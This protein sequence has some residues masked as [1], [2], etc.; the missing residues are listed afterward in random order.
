MALTKPSHSADLSQLDIAH[1]SFSPKGVTVYLSKQSQQ[2]KQVGSFFFLSLKTTK[3][4][5]QH[6]KTELLPFIWRQGKPCSFHSLVG[7]RTLVS[8]SNIERWLKK[9]LVQAGVDIS[10]F[11]VHSICGASASE[12]VASGVTMVDILTAADWSSEETFQC[13]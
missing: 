9:C 1:R 2:N 13:F 6:M 4:Y 8:S 12:A 11:Q 10:K 7:K 3:I 5:A